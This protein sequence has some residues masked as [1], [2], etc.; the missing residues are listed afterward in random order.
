MTLDSI[1]KGRMGELNTRFSHAL[2]LDPKVYHV[3][4]KVL[5]KTVPSTQ[6]DHIIVSNY[7]IFVVETKYRTGWIFGKR[8]E[9]RW[10][11]VLFYGKYQFQNPL[12]QNYLH[13]KSISEVIGVDHN[14]IH[15]VVVFRGNCQFKK[16]MPENVLYGSDTNYIKS[17]KLM[18]LPD[19]EVARICQELKYIKANTSFLDVWRHTQALKRR[20]QNVSACLDY[21]GFLIKPSQRAHLK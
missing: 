13:T 7:G 12:H 17:K 8:Y 5:L 18:L 14:K 10:T 11:Q 16:E 19:K 9:P 4:D 2:S 21:K 3:F 1:V 6:I 20:F 15:S